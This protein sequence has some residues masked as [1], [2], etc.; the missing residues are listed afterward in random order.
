M[1]QILD[2]KINEYDK[3]DGYNFIGN[4]NFLYRC[5]LCNKSFS[6]EK[7]DEHLDSKEHKKRVIAN[8]I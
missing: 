8:Q 5:Q 1:M 6:E 7:L 3:I 2:R 4:R